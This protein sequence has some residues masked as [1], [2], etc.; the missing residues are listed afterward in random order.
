VYIALLWLINFSFFFF[1]YSRSGFDFDFDLFEEI[2]I[3]ISNSFET[4]DF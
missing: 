1:F 4:G 2:V 3:L